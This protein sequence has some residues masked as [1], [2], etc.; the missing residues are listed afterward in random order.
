MQ[1]RFPDST[2]PDLDLNQI[3][4]KAEP[5]HPADPNG[6]TRVDITFRVKDDISGYASSGLFLR[7]PQGVIHGFNHQAPDNSHMYFSGDDP[8][9]YQTYQLT[10]TLPVGS[11][12]GTWGLAEMVVGDKAGNL[13]RA[14]FTEIVRFKVDDGTVYTKYDVNEDGVIGILDLVLVAQAFGKSNDKADVNGDGTVDILDL[15]EVASR[16]RRR[17]RQRLQSVHSPTAD[18]IQSWITQAMQTDDGSHA[19]RRG[20]RVLQNLLLNIH[21]ETTALLPNYPNPFNPET[22]IPYHLAK[23]ADVTLTIYATNGCSCSHNSV[24]ASGCWYVSKP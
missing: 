21:P 12:P 19:F 7:D 22:W 11:V 14:N 10:I 5:T 15:L 6:E 8:T 4:I 24:R 3:T 16:T 1:T 2:P 9:V 13:L 20:I 23:P 18:Q 17:K